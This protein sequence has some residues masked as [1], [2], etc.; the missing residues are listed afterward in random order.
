MY[1]EMMDSLLLTNVDILNKTR[2]IENTDI[3]VLYF[4]RYVN[5]KIKW[6]VGIIGTSLTI[7]HFK[8]GF[9]MNYTMKKQFIPTIT[10][11]LYNI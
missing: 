6:I 5:E 10:K 3:R 8:T 11:M 2:K 4:F 1:S 9:F 7:Q